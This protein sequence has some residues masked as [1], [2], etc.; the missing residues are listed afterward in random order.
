MRGSGWIDERAANITFLSISWLIGV[1]VVTAL[2]SGPMP[3]PAA[4]FRAGKPEYTRV[5]GLVRDEGGRPVA[6]VEVVLQGVNDLDKSLSVRTGADGKYAF[7][8]IKDDP[9]RYHSLAVMAGKEGFV[10]ALGHD[11]PLG[12]PRVDLTLVKEFVEGQGEWPK[13]IYVQTPKAI[14]NEA[15]SY[16]DQNR[17]LLHGMLDAFVAS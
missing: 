6:D 4:Q 13:G 14:L 2:A 9:N 3:A 11:S 1:C 10:P 17:Q 5:T 12:E 16:C 8:P 15:S 7:P